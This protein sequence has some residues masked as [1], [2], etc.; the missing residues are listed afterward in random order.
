MAIKELRVQGVGEWKPVQLFEREA[1]VLERLRHHGVPEFFRHFESQDQQGRLC[2]YLV[3]SSSMGS[4][5][6]KSW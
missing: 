2:L 5:S 3:M 6:S 1:V 4:R